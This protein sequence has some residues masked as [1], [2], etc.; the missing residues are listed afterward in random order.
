MDDAYLMIQSK[1]STI[2]A[3]ESDYYTVIYISI[4]CIIDLHFSRS[5]NI[6]SLIAKF[7]VIKIKILERILAKV[8]SY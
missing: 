6:L 7:K 2:Q 1:I 8:H 4:Y 3:N 5:L